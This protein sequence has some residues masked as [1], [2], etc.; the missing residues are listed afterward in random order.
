MDGVMPSGQRSDRARFRSAASRVLTDCAGGARRSFFCGVRACTSS[1]G[2]PSFPSGS[3]PSSS[4]LGASAMVGLIHTA[5]L[6]RQALS[7]SIRGTEW[8]HVFTAS[9]RGATSDL[10]NSWRAYRFARAVCLG[11]ARIRLEAARQGHWVAVGAGSWQQLVFQRRDAGGSSD[12][13]CVSRGRPLFARCW[14]A[15][16]RP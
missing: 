3:G 2:R 10:L 4:A 15:R 16:M 9:N 6:A 13:P 8:A 11:R 7:C 12:H 14:R 1:L 5:S